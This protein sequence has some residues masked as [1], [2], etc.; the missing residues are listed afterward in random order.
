MVQLIPIVWLLET[1]F[2]YVIGFIEQWN[3]ST[4]DVIL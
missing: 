2:R 1:I 4:P 3:V